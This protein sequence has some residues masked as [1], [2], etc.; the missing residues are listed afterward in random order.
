MITGSS[1]LAEPP[2]FNLPL[3]KPIRRTVLDLCIEAIYNIVYASFYYTV[4][5]VHHYNSNM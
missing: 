5:K 4:F 1:D 3:T 2:L